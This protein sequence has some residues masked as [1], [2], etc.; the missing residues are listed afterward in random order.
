M[1]IFYVHNHTDGSNLR[2]KD[3]IIKTQQLIDEAIRLGAKGLAITDHEYIGN[4]VKAI[5]YYNQLKEK[6]KLPKDFKVALGNEIYLIDKEYADSQRALNLKINFYHLILIAKSERGHKGIRELSSMA[7]LNRFYYRGFE[8]VPTYYHQLKEIMDKYKGEIICSTACLGGEFPNLFKQWHENGETQKDAAKI[9]S[10]INFL[11]D[12]FGEDLYIELQPSHNGEQKKFNS[13][14]WKYAKYK[15]IKPIITTDTHYLKKE[16]RIF[17]KYYLQSQNADREVDDF[18]A[19][20]YMMPVEEMSEFFDYSE[21]IDLNELIKNTHEI[22]E[23]VEM[24][25]FYKEQQIPT[26]KIPDFKLK[27]LFLEYYEKCEYLKYFANSQHKIDKYFLYLLEE[28]FLKKKQTICDKTIFRINT[29]M[30]ELWKISQKMKQRMSSYYVLTKDIIDIMWK[31]SLVGVSRGSS[32]GYYTCY[33]LDIVQMNPLDFELPHW[34]H[35][36][37]ERPKSWVL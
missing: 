19:T 10:F 15:G 12:M 16:H 9:N 23:K 36:V 37:A 7:W 3:S 1:N 25:D 20:T 22:H 4:H 2:G 24:Y 29:E 6:G 17:H 28:G 14:A 31:T 33:L 30:K 21:K 32:S 35:L 34:R 8:R 18:Y 26:T 27:H 5:R 13:F 11:K